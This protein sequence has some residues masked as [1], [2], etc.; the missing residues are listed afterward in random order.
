MSNLVGNR[1]SGAVSDLCRMN[2]AVTAKLSPLCSVVGEVSIADGCSVFAGAHIRGDV[3]PISVAART[4]IQENCCLHVSSG[5]PLK[6]GSGVTVGHGAIL[7]GC[8]IGDNCLIGMGSIVMDGAVVGEGC[9]VG[10]G[11]LITQGKEFA[12]KSLIMGSPARAV[13]KLTDDEIRSQ[14]AE[15]ADSYCELADSM[16]RD[17]LMSNPSASDDIW[18]AP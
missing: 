3:A 2:A 16:V 1:M 17:G 5:H 15:P 13:R 9:L 18:P 10:A 4:N 6:I 11:S 7:H 14:I 8:S 12:P